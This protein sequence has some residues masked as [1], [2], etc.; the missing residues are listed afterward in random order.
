MYLKNF[1]INKIPNG[2]KQKCFLLTAK[3]VFCSR[4]V[5]FQA[6]TS[7]WAGNLWE[8]TSQA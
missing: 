1:V 2:G 4:Y 8:T 3:L 7:S 5:T 6:F